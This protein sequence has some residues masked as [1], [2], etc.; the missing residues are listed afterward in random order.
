MFKNTP[1][2]NL[3]GFSQTWIKK[4]SNLIVLFHHKIYLEWCRVCQSKVD[5][6]YRIPYNPKTSVVR[7]VENGLKH[8][9]Y[10]SHRNNYNN[11]P[12]CDGI[13]YCFELRQFFW[14]EIFHQSFIFLALTIK[15]RQHL[16]YIGII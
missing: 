16:K 7:I 2:I 8:P 11:S 4:I 15:A 12:K 13:V 9:L 10:A 14:K 3:H 1:V 6:N 5:K